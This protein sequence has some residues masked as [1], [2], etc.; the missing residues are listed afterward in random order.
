MTPWTTPICP[1]A[2]PIQNIARMQVYSVSPALNRRTFFT[3]SRAPS[4]PSM[5]LG[6]CFKLETMYSPLHLAA[7]VALL[8]R[9][10]TLPIHGLRQLAMGMLGLMSRL[11]VWASPA[12]G[13]GTR[14]ATVRATTPLKGLGRLS[15]AMC[16]AKLLR[17]CPVLCELDMPC[18]TGRITTMLHQ[19][20][21]PVT[22]TWNSRTLRALS[23]QRGGS[24]LRRA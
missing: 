17:A 3:V 10:P 11:S 15:L 22:V 6:T 21:R 16:R 19:A 2:I 5:S 9:C 8:P 7:V 4:A 13:A 12:M 1:S 20:T 23:L 18:L 24:E 14:S